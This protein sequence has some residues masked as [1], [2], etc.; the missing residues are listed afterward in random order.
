MNGTCQLNAAN[1][2]RRGVTD[3]YLGRE[4][5]KAKHFVLKRY[6]QALAHKVLRFYDVTYVDGFSGPWETKT[7]NF[8][9]TSFMIAIRV[10]KDAQQ[11]VLESTGIHRQIRCFF[12]EVNLKM[13]LRL[14]RA[15]ASSKM[16][17][18]KFNSLL[19]NPFL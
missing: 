7:K 8:S 10:L 17:L 11:R 19:V 4:Q 9:D 6:L 15:A 14:R 2:E 12:S 1:T 13:A 18:M 3:P 5:T 16:P